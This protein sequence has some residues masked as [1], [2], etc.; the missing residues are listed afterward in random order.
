MIY[1]RVLAAVEHG[2]EK[3]RVK[4]GALAHYLL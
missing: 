3:Q 2:G 1:V 4:H